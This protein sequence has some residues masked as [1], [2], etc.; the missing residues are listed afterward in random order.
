MC[1]TELCSLLIYQML[2]LSNSDVLCFFSYRG[3][4]SLIP[5]GA[6]LSRVLHWIVLQARSRLNS[7]PFLKSASSYSQFQSDITLGPAPQP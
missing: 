6:K 4:Y 1:S 3:P 2:F 7:F 5:P